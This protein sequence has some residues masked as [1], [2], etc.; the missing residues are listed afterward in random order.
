[1]ACKGW[2][3]PMERTKVPWDHFEECTARAGYPAFDPTMARFFAK[4][5]EE[6]DKRKVEDERSGFGPSATRLLGCPRA[7]VIERE[8]DWWIN[9]ANSAMM[10][11]GSMQHEKWEQETDEEQWTSERRFTGK[12]GG[13][14]VV[15]VVDAHRKDWSEILDRK[16]PNDFSVRF[17]GT[18]AKPD[19]RVQLNIARLLIA[20]DEE[21]IKEGY[22]PDRVK[23]TLWDYG[24]GQGDPPKALTVKHMTEA[25]VLQHHGGSTGKNTAKYTVENNLELLAWAEEQKRNG[26]EGETIA[27]S[28]PMVG[29][30]Q[31]NGDKCTKYCG[32]ERECSSLVKKFGYPEAVEFEGVG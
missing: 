10:I 7:A 13:K 23:L 25:Q 19:H 30:T 21:A 24:I 12:L 11:R 6:Y 2:I 8:M 16:F 5:Q 20:Q 32:V 15:V 17:R 22:D 31:F 14:D 1:M 3:C 4:K 28:L 18:E 9:P 27:A 26:V 29:E